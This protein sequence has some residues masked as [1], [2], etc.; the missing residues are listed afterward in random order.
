MGRRE[1][2][3]L[4]ARWWAVHAELTQAERKRFAPAVL[5]QLVYAN[6][7]MVGVRYRP[8]ELL[9]LALVDAGICMEAQG[10]YRFAFPWFTW[11]RLEADGRVYLHSGSGPLDWHPLTP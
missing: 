10:R 9:H 4:V 11:T 8:D 3:V 5:R 6:P 1:Q 2:Y 7:T